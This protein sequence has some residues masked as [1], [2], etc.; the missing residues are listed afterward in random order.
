MAC[1]SRTCHDAGCWRDLPAASREQN[2]PDG[3]A[4]ATDKMIT[5][6]SSYSLM[7][8]VQ[9]TFERRR[10]TI[11]ARRQGSFRP[12]DDRTMLGPQSEILA[13]L[14]EEK[15]QT[16]QP[17]LPTPLMTDPLPEFVSS[18]QAVLLLHELCFCQ[19]WPALRVTPRNWRRRWLTQRVNGVV[20]GR[21]LFVC[22][23]HAEW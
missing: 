8:P 15:P 13:R 9:G 14:V 1:R 6:H 18:K 23:R 21:G 7:R 20:S 3:K 10:A 12:G 17:V 4:P 22:C 16:P 5:I 19:G 2:K 11:E